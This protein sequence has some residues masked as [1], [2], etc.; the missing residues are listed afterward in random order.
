[1]DPVPPHIPPLRPETDPDG[2]RFDF[3]P[4]RGD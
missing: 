2:R 3:I 4:G 1:V